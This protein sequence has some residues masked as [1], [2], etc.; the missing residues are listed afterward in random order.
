[1]KLSD[2]NYELPEELIAQFPI[3]KRDESRLLI[4]DKISGKIEEKKFYQIADYIGAGDVLVVNKTRVINARLYGEMDIFPKGKKEIKKVEIFLHKQISHNVWECLGYPGKNLKIGRN[5]RFYD[6]KWDIILSGLIQKVSEMGRFIEFD[7]SGLEFFQTIE[8]I[9][10]IPLP[11][12]ITQKLSNID[13]Y[14]TVYA[15]EKGS[16]AAPTAWLHFTSDLLDHLRQKWVIIEEVLLHVGVGTFKPVETNDITDHQMHSEYIELKADVAERLN[17]YKSNWKRI[18][19][20]GTTSVRVLESFAWDDGVL[21]AWSKETSIFIY[22]GYT[23]KFVN[24]L[25]TNFHLPAS[26]LLMLVSA[27]ATKE[28]IKTAYEYAVQNKF[29]F[30]SF[31]DAMFIK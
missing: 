10:E 28:H 12:Y 3:E 25:V 31:W 18:I 14:Q 7:K 30:F 23:W 15:K 13:R 9:W 20:V 5:I 29:R 24:A 17:Q 11:P 26:T 2:F 4:L 27:L 1:M 6:E 22:P 19:A 16:V 21:T 8:S